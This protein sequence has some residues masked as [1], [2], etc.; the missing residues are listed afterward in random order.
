MSNFVVVMFYFLYILQYLPLKILILILK[1]KLAHWSEKQ[2]WSQTYQVLL[3]CFLACFVC[4]SSS[5]QLSSFYTFL[6]TWCIPEA[7]QYSS[8]CFPSSKC[9]DLPSSIISFHDIFFLW[10]YII[11]YSF[12]FIFVKFMQGSERNK[13][14]H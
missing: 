11:F 4:A 7:S 6:D 13:Y 8:I 12:I 14:N 9:F 2:Q 1:I 10:V 5:P 3:S